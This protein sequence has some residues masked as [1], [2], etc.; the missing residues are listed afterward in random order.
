MSKHVKL[1]NVL[2]L[3]RQILVT[4]IEALERKK[5]HFTEMQNKKFEFE[6][7]RVQLDGANS[8]MAKHRSG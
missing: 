3:I 2:M 1:T 4:R 8:N 5:E 7:R 6:S